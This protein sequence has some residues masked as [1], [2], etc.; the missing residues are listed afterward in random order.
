MREVGL[1]AQEAE[2]I[3]VMLMGAIQQKYSSRYMYL[4]MA[5]IN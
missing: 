1:E 5:T 4:K 3:N 2:A